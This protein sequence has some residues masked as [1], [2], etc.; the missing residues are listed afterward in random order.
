MNSSPLQLIKK[1]GPRW[2]RGTNKETGGWER[3]AEVVE[4]SGVED[5]NKGHTPCDSS[6]RSTLGSGSSTEC[7]ET[8]IVQTHQDD[9]PWETEQE[10]DSDTSRPAFKR[11]RHDTTESA[12]HQP[13]HKKR[14]RRN[15]RM[16]HLMKL[17]LREI[18]QEG[19]DFSIPDWVARRKQQQKPSLLLLVDSQLKFWLAS[20][21]ICHVICHEKWPL[22]RWNQAIKLG[23]IRVQSFTVILYLE[24]TRAWMDAPPVKNSLTTL[25]NTIRAHGNNPRIF[26][27]NHLPY[28]GTSPIQYPVPHSNFTLQQAIRSTS[29]SLKGMIFELSVFEH[30]TSTR[31]KTLKPRDQFFLDV[32][33]L[34]PLGCMVFCECI[35]RECGIKS[36]W[37][38]EKPGKPL[39]E[40]ESQVKR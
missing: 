38:E 23:N 28:V 34:T 8:V 18:R 31:G 33:N 10:Q 14:D 29:R 9:S 35:M 20:D 37:F 11:G 1:H 25:C 27:C 24:A 26:V 19:M 3:P 7:H 40:P 4:T 36:Y 32:D 39:Q 12:G 15:K 5:L 22:K 16:D 21:N 13:C 2:S 6:P 30:F 17:A